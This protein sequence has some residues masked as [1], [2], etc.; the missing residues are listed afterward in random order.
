[1]YEFKLRTGHHRSSKVVVFGLPTCI[2]FQPRES[3]RNDREDTKP[4]TKSDHFN[5]FQIYATNYLMYKKQHEKEFCFLHT[6]ILH[7]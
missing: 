4:G 7:A 5:I 3:N 2:T 6:L 1:M